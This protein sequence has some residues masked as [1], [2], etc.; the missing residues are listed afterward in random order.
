MTKTFKFGLKTIFFYVI[1]ERTAQTWTDII[2]SLTHADLMYYFV[3]L[4]SIFFFTPH[5]RLRHK[6][7]LNFFDNFRDANF[8]LI[9][10]PST[11][12]ARTPPPGQSGGP[13][14]PTRADHVSTDTSCVESVSLHRRSTFET[15]RVDHDAWC[16]EGLRTS[17]TKSLALVSLRDGRLLTYLLASRIEVTYFCFKCTLPR[18]ICDLEYFYLHIFVQKSK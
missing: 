7:W 11:S 12:G 4:T 17:K 13:P 15:T 5:A 1:R 6:L 10:A 3:A 14:H 16:E 8:W 2:H 9:R 18:Q